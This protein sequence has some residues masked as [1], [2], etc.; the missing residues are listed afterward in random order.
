MC[1]PRAGPAEGPLPTYCPARR[2]WKR[3]SNAP[4]C[5]RFLVTLAAAIR[6][7][8]A[9]RSRASRSRLGEPCGGLLRVQVHGGV[10]GFFA[11]ASRF[12]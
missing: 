4:I 9:T 1:W 7:I 6:V 3:N 11:E 8:S 10:F 5:A 12:C 2:L